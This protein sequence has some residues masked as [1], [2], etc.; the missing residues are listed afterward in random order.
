VG[1]H[2]LRFPASYVD[3]VLVEKYD[4]TEAEPAAIDG[5]MFQLSTQV[6]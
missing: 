4:R 1:I 5:S 3:V 2:P 6:E